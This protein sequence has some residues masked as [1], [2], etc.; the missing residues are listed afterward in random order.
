MK[1]FIQ[2]LIARL[3]GNEAPQPLV[4]SEKTPVETLVIKEYRVQIF[5]G[6]GVV[7]INAKGINEK[8]AREKA[9]Q[10]YIRTLKVT[11]RPI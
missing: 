7:K 6:A 2:T 1:K 10:Q 9:I 8:E 3:S 5:N 4:D 11:T